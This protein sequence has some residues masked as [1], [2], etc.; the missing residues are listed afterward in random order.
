[1]FRIENVFPTAWAMDAFHALVSFGRGIEAVVFPSAAL[2][3]FGVVFA[4][5]GARALRT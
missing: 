3:V 4:G 5:I 2:L 1:M